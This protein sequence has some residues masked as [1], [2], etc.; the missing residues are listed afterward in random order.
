MFTVGSSLIVD[1]TRRIAT[2]ALPDAPVVGDVESAPTSARA[3]GALAA[4]LRSVAA[5]AGSAAER[6]EPRFG[7]GVRGA[8]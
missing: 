8:S 1:C 6:V 4:A 7:I 2:S 5:R 3:R